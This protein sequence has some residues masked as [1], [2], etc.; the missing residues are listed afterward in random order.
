[1]CPR[2]HLGHLSHEE[3]FVMDGHSLNYWKKTGY[4]NVKSVY[5][6]ICPYMYRSYL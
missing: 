6:R 5:V 4:K 1:M 2:C 3:Y